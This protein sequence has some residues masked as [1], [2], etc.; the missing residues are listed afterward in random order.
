MTRS[1]VLSLGALTCLVSQGTKEVQAAQNKNQTFGTPRKPPRIVVVVSRKNP[2]ES[3]T[4]ADLARIFL[5]R[6]TQWSNG[7]SSTVY[8]RPV[9]ENRRQ[10]LSHNSLKQK[11]TELHEYCMN[12]EVTNGIKPP[13]V[14][15]S[16]KLVKRYLERVK[17][18]IA[19]LYD[20]EI[21]DTVKV[22]E[23][24]KTA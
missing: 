23:S 1:I 14:L 16:T 24:K 22:F 5:R 11:P 8:E 2:I 9:E 12:L 10:S 17:S 18:G 7:R 6:K 15:R 4:T 21:D 19:Y 13:R 20:H 3:L